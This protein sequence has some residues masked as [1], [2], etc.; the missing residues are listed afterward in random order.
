VSTDVGKGPESHTLEL[1]RTFENVKVPDLGSIQNILYTC[2]STKNE[3]INY[4]NLECQL[5]ELL[6][7]VNVSSKSQS[8]NSNV[9]QSVN[10]SNIFQNPSNSQFVYAKN[11]NQMYNN[12]Q[13]MNSQYNNNNSTGH[14][15]QNYNQ[16]YNNNQ[17]YSHFPDQKSQQNENDIQRFIAKFKCSRE[18]AVGYLEAFGNYNEAE[19]QF[20]LNTGWKG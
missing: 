18:M 17:S 12:T 13:N 1:L 14:F 11:Q 3:Y 9:N 10:N 15:G 2:E 16:S 20:I 5:E 19:T 8:Y 4:V 6:Q 7:K